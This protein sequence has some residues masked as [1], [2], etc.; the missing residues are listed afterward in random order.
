M[1]TS[2]GGRCNNNKKK[3]HTTRFLC[4]EFDVLFQA[5]NILRFCAGFDRRT[6]QYHAD[7]NQQTTR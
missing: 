1:L 3:K 5:D 6:G 7:G 4:I 2:S